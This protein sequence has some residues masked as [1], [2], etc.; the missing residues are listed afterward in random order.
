MSLAANLA[1]FVCNV[2]SDGLI[3]GM[4]GGTIVNSV[5]LLP[6]NAYEGQT[7]LETSTNTLYVYDGEKWINTV[8]Q[9]SIDPSRTLSVND[10]F[11]LNAN[12][13]TSFGTPEGLWADN[14][15]NRIIV[16]DNNEAR[17]YVLSSAWD[18]ST[19]SE[20]QGTISWQHPNARVQGGVFSVDGTKLVIFD[21]DEGGDLF[22]YDLT[23]PFDIRDTSKTYNSQIGGVET[24]G[25]YISNVGNL[26]WYDNGYKLFMSSNR[27]PAFEIATV[28]T[29]YTLEGFSSGPV[30]HADLTSFYSGQYGSAGA[31]LQKDGSEVFFF[32][33]TFNETVIESYP[34]ITSFDPSSL[35]TGSKQTG[36]IPAIGSVCWMH[37][38]ANKMLFADGSTIKLLDVAS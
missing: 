33:G 26:Y 27:Y 19:A 6:L 25:N 35:S 24:A 13:F 14:N 37:P 38:E 36:T 10:T 29:P 11:T 31:F 17:Q 18:L 3:P 1:K 9:I 20:E 30:N 4:G 5:D 12:S 34:M 23:S 2:D 7:V 16:V 15:G 8:L 32:G 28:T 22:Q 21:R